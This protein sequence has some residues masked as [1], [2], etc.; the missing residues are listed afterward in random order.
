MGWGQINALHKN[1][2]KTKSSVMLTEKFSQCYGDIF[3]IDG[4]T[5]R[6]NLK[7]TKG[8]L[9]LFRAFFVILS[10]QAGI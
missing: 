10:T 9:S 8:K 2:L 3:N 4:P 5:G 1:Y 7:N 6:I